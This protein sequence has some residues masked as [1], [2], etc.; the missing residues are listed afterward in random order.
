MTTPEAW[1]PVIFS[2]PNLVTFYF[3]KLTHF[4]D[5]M[6]NT[7]LSICST[8][9]LVRLQTANMKNCLTTKNPKMCD[10]IIVSPP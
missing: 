7:L 4:L 10:P 3:Y 9:I 1:T 5:W 8:N 6:K 2:D